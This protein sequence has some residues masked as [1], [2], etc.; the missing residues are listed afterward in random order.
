MG[1]QQNIQGPEWSTVSKNDMFTVKRNAAGLEVE[2]YST[3]LPSKEAM[4][5]VEEELRVR[6]NRFGPDD[7]V[8][9]LL[10]Y[11][12][13]EVPAMCSTSYNVLTVVERIPRRLT[14]VHG[15]REENSVYL[16]HE[17]VSGY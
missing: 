14:D 11:Q 6:K 3:M 4:R 10:G 17:M 13:L 2:E 16:L 1:N 7:N 5:L 8:V 15:I 12:V 9:E